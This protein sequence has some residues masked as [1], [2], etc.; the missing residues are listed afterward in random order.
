MNLLYT[1]FKLA[2]LFHMGK[3]VATASQLALPQMCP[4]FFTTVP[5]SLQYEIGKV[6]LKI[7]GIL[8]KM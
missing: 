7:A 8:E 4:D 1:V 3:Q 6:Q 2:N 5:S